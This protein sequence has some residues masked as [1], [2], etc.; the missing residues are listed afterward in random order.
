MLQRKIGS[1][2]WETSAIALGIMRMSALTST[3][4]AEV[5]ETALESGINFI[6][7][8]DMY[9]DGKSEL[10][11]GEALKEANISRDKFFIQ[12]KGGIVTG[13]EKRYDFSKQHLLDSVDGI[14][15]RMGIDYLDSYLLHRPDPLM[16]PEEI[17]EAFDILQA[18]GK[19]RHFGVSNF[20]PEQ[21]QLLQAH[22]DQKLLINQLQF[23]IMHT[24]MIDY[25]M[26]TNMTDTRSFDH[27]GGVL[28]F[29][30]RKGV[31][32]QAWSP[33]QYGFFEGVFVDNDKFPELNELLEKLAKKYNTNKNAIATA[34]I[35][36]HPANMQVILGT[37]NPTRIKE[38]AA[39]G[40]VTLTKQ[41]WY[42]IYFAAGNDLP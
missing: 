22:V 30:R 5:L 35:L 19:V 27:D 4:A 1:S 15:E 2:Y 40:E 10:V 28:E 32:I 36:R 38:S 37:M 33:F 31:T 11:F 24:G 23:S 42:D 21:F 16:E 41:E 29:S 6:D 14:L 9:G 20:N 18:S 13:D 26:H 34:W 25:G 17:A 12:S 8:A 39:G 7:S 3:K